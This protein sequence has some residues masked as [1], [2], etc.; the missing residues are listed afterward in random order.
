MYNFKDFKN[1]LIEK[2]ALKA[3]KVNVAPGA[4]AQHNGNMSEIAFD[5]AIRA[6]HDQRSAG[7]SHEEAIHHVSNNIRPLRPSSLSKKHKFYDFVSKSISAYG[8]PKVGNAETRRTLWDGHHAA[9]KVIDHIHKNYGPI[10]GKPFHTGPDASG[11]MAK[12]LTGAPT[13]ADVLIPYK[14]KVSGKQELIKLNSR[15]NTDHPEEGK[16]GSHIGASLKYSIKPGKS[17]TKVRGHGVA[18]FHE[19]IQTAHKKIFGEEHHDLRKATEG[20]IRGPGEGLQQTLSTH[21][22]Y[23][24]SLFGTNN[25][26]GKGKVIDTNKK[27]AQAA[28]FTHDL[29]SGKRKLNAAAMSVLRKIRDGRTYNLKIADDHSLDHDPIKAKNVYNELE[30]HGKDTLDPFVDHLHGALHRIMHEHDPNN[31]DH[32][33]AVHKLAR[34][35]SNVPE[36]RSNDATSGA[37]TLLVSIKRQP[38]KGPTYTKPTVYI[39]NPVTAHRNYI[40]RSK[41]AGADTTSMFPV[42]R[43]PGS[44]NIRVGDATLT[45]YRASSGHSS[46]HV[47][48][49]HGFHF[50]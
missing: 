41:A 13:T 23:L 38:S 30:S 16:T 19:L 15:I 4:I 40:D 24:H 1:Y 17:P 14:D 12:K 49:T 26:P 10:S 2:S 7:K 31:K 45:A 28:T 11:E 29:K 3:A 46:V 33:R 34:Q 32:V 36:R 25:P 39:G 8:N 27:P 37:K 6:Y 20:L 21:H 44:K 9:V 18:G 48:H 50:G 5:N 42:S 43:Q 35:I 22:D 47:T